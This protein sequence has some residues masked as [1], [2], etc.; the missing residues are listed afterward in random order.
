M[1]A[2]IR[3]VAVAAILA[4]AAAAPAQ[5]TLDLIPEDAA[6]GV[7]VRNIADL[8]KK[9]DKFLADA[10]IM[11]PVNATGAFDELAKLLGIKDGIDEDGS[12]AVVV[13]NPSHAGFKKVTDSNQELIVAV[14]PFTD[15]DKIGA[16][17]NI[18]AG[19]LK[20]GVVVTGEAMLF[21]KFFAV[22][23]KHLFIGN[24]EKALLSVV[25]GKGVGGALTAEQKRRFADA[26][27]LVHAGTR[28]WGDEWKQFLKLVEEGLAGKG[29]EAEK[30]LV[31]Q[32]VESMQEVRFVL[33]SAR[34]DDGVGVSLM[35]VLP[36]KGG[37][38]ARKFL[39]SLEGGPGT[40]DLAG[41]PDGPAVLAQ[42]A[43]GD[44]A[45]N[46]LIM[47]VLIEFLFRDVFQA[48]WL[49]PE[50]DRAYVVG[51]FGEVWKHLKGNRVAV[52]RNADPIEKGLFS[53]VSILDT[54]DGEKFV[55]S[56]KLLSK[57]AGGAGLEPTGKGAQDD[58]AA[59]E[60]LIRDLG[61]DS[62]EVRESASTKL[63]LIGE[64]ALPLLEKALQ[65]DDAEVRRRAEDLKAKIVDAALA[66][67]KD[68]LAKDAPWRLRP[69]FVFAGVEEKAGR[70]VE[71]VRMKLTERDAGAAA[72]LKD[73]LGPDWDRMRLAVEGKQVVVLLGSDERLLHEA[74]ANLK[75]GKP[76]LAASKAVAPFVKQSGEGRKIEAHFSL[77]T[78]LELIK[79]EDL[80][81]GKKPEGSPALTSVALT[82]A[83][84]RLQ[85]DVRVP[86]AEI[87]ALAA[88]AGR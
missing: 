81:A 77:A 59:V 12:A 11:L 71:T 38:A 80:R 27:A 54:E 56:M 29:G 70:R 63:A 73:V 1:S 16:N 6:A 15:A 60:K 23:G 50:E 35:A 28:S 85:I 34:V 7:A 48:P 22:R 33:G 76:G 87:K 51:V 79:A 47:K 36:E 40:S 31:G 17:F 74:L 8:R 67:R 10:E 13:A 62:F 44:G 32:L 84:D 78:V 83:A 57:F 46:V 18:K 24:H 82:V 25:N 66:R 14:V 68:L 26:D 45:Q 49:P 9:G 2:R 43:R 39:A 55:A 4:A 58:V 52:Y 41:L 86:V 42:A 64:R 69:S 88:E 37:D 61:D 65:S 75:D 53:V 5:G 20:P 72:A 30:K 19:E 21:G 3:L